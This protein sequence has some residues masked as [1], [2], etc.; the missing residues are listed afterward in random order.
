MLLQNS[1]TFQLLK[2]NLKKKYL[3]ELISNIE[4][5]C[6]IL[7]VEYMYII[8]TYCGISSAMLVMWL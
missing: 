2:L 6:S 8:L 7:C 5:I 1:T 3:R 4:V